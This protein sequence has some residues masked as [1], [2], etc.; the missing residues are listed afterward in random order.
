MG[1]WRLGLELNF[2]GVGT[3]SNN[4]DI[5]ETET[6]F[7]SKLIYQEPDIDSEGLKHT[8]EAMYCKYR[9]ESLE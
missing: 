4:T 1:P 5:L 8:P 7:D 6:D 2:L 9:R 3:R